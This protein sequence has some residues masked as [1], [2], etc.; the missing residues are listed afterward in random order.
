MKKQKKELMILIVQTAIASRK[1]HGQIRG[2]SH[3]Y[4]QL[5]QE[6]HSYLQDALLYRYC[7]GAVFALVRQPN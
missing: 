6:D 3:N 4:C 5:E 1:P 2:C 7:V